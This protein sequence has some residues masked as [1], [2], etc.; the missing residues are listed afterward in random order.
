MKQNIFIESVRL[1]KFNINQYSL[2]AS[3]FVIMCNK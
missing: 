1:N 2:S 3:K